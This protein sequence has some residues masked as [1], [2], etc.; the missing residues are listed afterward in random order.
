MPKVWILSLKTG[1]VWFQ[2]TKGE[3]VLVEQNS[4][5]N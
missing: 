2:K 4:D 1:L 3:V 5:F